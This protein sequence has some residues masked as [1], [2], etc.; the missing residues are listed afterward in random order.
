[1]SLIQATVAL[2]LTRI[3]SPLF[4][5]AVDLKIYP[6]CAKGIIS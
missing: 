3:F 4:H 2:L 5:S 1:M 6:R